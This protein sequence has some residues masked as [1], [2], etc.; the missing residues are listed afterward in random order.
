L[1]IFADLFIIAFICMTALNK[2]TFEQVYNVREDEDL[3]AKVSQVICVLLQRGIMV[4]GF[5]P[6]RELL[7]IHYTG[8]NA[9][10]PV[11]ALDFFEHIFMQETLFA[12]REK[13]KGVFILSDRNLI[14]PDDLYEEKEAGKWLR[15]IHYTEPKEAIEA[16][17]L[18]EDKATYLYAIATGIQ[19]LIK[20]NFKKATVLPAPVYHFRNA[21]KQSLYL[22]CCITADQVCATLHNYSQLLWHRAFDYTCAEDIAFGIKHLCMENNISP[23]KIAFRCDAVSAAEHEVL[24]TLS[25]Y[26][27]GIRSGKGAINKNWDAAISLSQLLLECVL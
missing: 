18:E 14:V 26:F 17:N 21:R 27:P 13:V 11:W 6:T 15:R 3:A 16:C 20:I 19:E 2:N 12:S 23:S 22:Q 9:T 1:N 5:S 4:A 10:K 7:V 24:T 25:Q 8:Y